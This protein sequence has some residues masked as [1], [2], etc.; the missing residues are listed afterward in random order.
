M[1]RYCAQLAIFLNSEMG[2]PSNEIKTSGWLVS[3]H[4]LVG[5]SN[6]TSHLTTSTGYVTEFE[7]ALRDYSCDFWELVKLARNNRDPARSHGKKK[8]L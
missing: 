4:C 1:G 7:N 3:G 6:Q 2:R 5:L 8:T